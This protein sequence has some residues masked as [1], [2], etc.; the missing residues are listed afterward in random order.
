MDR[1]GLS[2]VR[3]M[4]GC[5]ADAVIEKESLLTEIDEKIGDGDHGIGMARGFQAVKEQ[6]PKMRADTVNELFKEVGM[7]LLDAMGGASGVIFGTMFISGCGAVPPTDYMSVDGLAS[8]LKRSLDKIKE[9]GGA[10]PGDKTMIDGYEP[11]VEALL[12]AA[13]KG[14]TL[15]EALRAAKEAAKKGMERTKGYSAQKGRAESYGDHS[16]GIPDPGAV[17]VS[18]IM[19]AMYKYVQNMEEE[20]V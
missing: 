2:E 16:K 4:F 17:S 5:I 14:D 1:I 12:M 9:R 13:G 11:A 3:E 20:R 10:R 15:A 6:L 19:D 18:I 7:T 8:M